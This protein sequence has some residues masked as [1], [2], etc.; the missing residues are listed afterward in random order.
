[1]IDRH[2]CWPPIEPAQAELRV[3]MRASQ[4]RHL[5]GSSPAHVPL[6]DE[7]TRTWWQA[8]LGIGEARWWL[9]L[10]EGDTAER[11][12]AVMAPHNGGAAGW[13][14]RFGY[15]LD[16][17]FVVLPQVGCKYCGKRLDWPNFYIGK[18]IGCRNWQRIL[19]S[20]TLGLLELPA[21]GWRR[22]RYAVRRRRNATW[23]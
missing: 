15:L 5:A 12:P 20:V 1:M 11:W 22:L 21:R 16:S 19:I 13:S 9:D 10:E 6:V 3:R 8:L 4:R 7:R 17:T 18:R 14:C 2:G 23:R